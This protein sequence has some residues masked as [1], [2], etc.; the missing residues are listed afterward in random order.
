MGNSHAESTSEKVPSN[1]KVEIFFDG[2][3]PL[4][5]RE[6]ALM[7]RLDRNGRI[8]FTDIAAADFRAGE[9]GKQHEEFMSEI[10]GRL[11]DG[12]WIRGVEVFRRVY[13]E[14][15]LKPI[16]W[17]SRLPVLRTV[18]E[19]VYFA[20]ARNRLRWTGRCSGDASTCNTS[21]T[22]RGHCTKS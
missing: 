18:L 21:Q 1:W 6:I 16:V 4:C 5:R 11:R 8:R 9:F 12:T 14:V 3:C 19:K 7:R 13:A 17:I 22:R 2:E 20:F 10:Q 15:G